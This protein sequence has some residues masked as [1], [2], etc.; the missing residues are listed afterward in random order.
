[1][2]ISDLLLTEDNARKRNFTRLKSV[3]D[4]SKTKGVLRIL[5]GLL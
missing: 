2:E 1:M 5:Y 4:F 3:E